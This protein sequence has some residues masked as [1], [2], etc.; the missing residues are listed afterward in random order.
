MTRIACLQVAPQPTFE[1]ATQAAL[2]LA[3]DAVSQ[4]AEALF[5]PEYAAGFRVNAGRFA[6]PTAEESVNP[7]VSAMRR[8]AR[9]R[10]VWVHAGSF[11]T[12]APSGKLY[13]R[14]VVI[15]PGG[16]VVARYDKIH[17]FD[18]QLSDNEVYRESDV[19]APGDEACLVD[20]GWATLGCSICYDLRFPGLYEAL[21]VNGATVLAIPAAFTRATGAVH[22]HALCRARAIENGAWVIAACSVGDIEGGGGCYGHSLVIDPWGTIVADGGDAPGVIIADIDVHAAAEARQRIPRLTHIRPFHIRRHA[23]EAAV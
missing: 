12:P 18:I 10:G 6:P 2:A 9:E 13:N 20:T 3:D 14:S 8:F 7:Y 4:G 23:A 15:D 22:W 17:L 1:S 19:V 16:E 21:A 11:A 5:L